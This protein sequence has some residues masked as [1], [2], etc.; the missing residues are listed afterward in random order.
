MK[1][2]LSNR[3]SFFKEKLSKEKE[4]DEA[5]PKSSLGRVGYLERKIPHDQSL[6]EHFFNLIPGYV[7]NKF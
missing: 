5:R 3:I 6:T 7:T 2:D 1:R 4:W